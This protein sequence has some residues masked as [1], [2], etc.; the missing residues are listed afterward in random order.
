MRASKRTLTEY[1]RMQAQELAITVLLAELRSFWWY[2]YI[3][4]K[5]TGTLL[6]VLALK[7]LMD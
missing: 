7:I 1:R 4:P 2:L 6:V 3:S 5:V